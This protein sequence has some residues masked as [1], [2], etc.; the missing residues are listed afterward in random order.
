MRLKATTAIALITCAAAPAFAQ[1]K[2]EVLGTYADIAQAGYE[3]SLTTAQ[4]LQA[5]VETAAPSRWRRH[6]RTVHLG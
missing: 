1:D 5:A 6:Q 2:A 4:T 3:D